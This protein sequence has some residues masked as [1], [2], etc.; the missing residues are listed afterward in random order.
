MY[1]QYSHHEEHKS[2]LGLALNQQ[3]VASKRSKSEIEKWNIML[4][5]E[6]SVKFA[7]RGV[8]F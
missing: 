6:L 1:F 2:E 4:R 5:H 7:V 3:Q 8:S